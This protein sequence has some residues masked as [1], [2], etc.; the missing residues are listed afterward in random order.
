MTPVGV[1][2]VDDDAADRSHS[3]GISVGA[4]IPLSDPRV[5]NIDTGALVPGAGVGATHSTAD[6]SGRVQR[7]T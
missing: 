2:E 4:P 7:H 6:P 1:G 5:G 3:S